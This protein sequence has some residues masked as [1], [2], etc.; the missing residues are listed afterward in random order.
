MFPLGTVLL[1]GMVLPL[2]VFEPRYRM[3]IRTV[4]AASGELGIV[5]IERGHEVGGGDTR[6][7]VACRARVA[8]AEELPDGRFVLAVVGLEPVTVVEWLPDDPFPQARVAPRADR[9]T[10][11]GAIAAARAAVDDRLTR[12]VALVG[13]PGAPITLPLDASAAAWALGAALGLGPLDAQRLLATAGVTDRLALLAEALDDR[14]LL[15]L[16]DRSDR[17]DRPEAAP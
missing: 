15:A 13:P 8:Q 3:M 5:L 9:A 1:P 2:H 16:A 11:A 4:L 14:L 10:D 7:D 12:L 6:F 17:G